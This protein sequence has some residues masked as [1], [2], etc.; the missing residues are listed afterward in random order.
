MPGAD[1]TLTAMRNNKV[2][3]VFVSGDASKRTKKQIIDKATF[4]GVPLKVLTLSAD[5][6]SRALG[7]VSPCAVFAVGMKGPYKKISEAI[8]SEEELN[9]NNQLTQEIQ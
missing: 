3:A 8:S 5:D 7:L 2:S 4:Y 1:V 6:V 9:F